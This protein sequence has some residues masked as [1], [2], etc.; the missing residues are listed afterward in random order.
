MAKPTPSKQKKNKADK[1]LTL[2]T[3]EK[4]EKVSEFAESKDRENDVTKTID[5]LAKNEKHCAKAVDKNNI[6]HYET[7]LFAVAGQRMLPFDIKEER[8]FLAL[9]VKIFNEGEM[10]KSVRCIEYM[11]QKRWGYWTYQVIRKP[12]DIPCCL[13]L[14]P[15]GKPSR[16]PNYYRHLILQSE[17]LLPG[18]CRFKTK[19]FLEIL[20]HGTTPDFSYIVVESANVSL[21]D[22]RAKVL[23]GADYSHTTAIQIGLQ[24]LQAINDSFCCSVL[25]RFIHPKNLFM[26][27]KEKINTIFIVD[28]SMGLLHCSSYRSISGKET[29]RAQ[30]RYP[31]LDYRY[32]PRAYH[33]YEDHLT[34][35]EV[36]SFIYV[37]LD[38]WTQ[39][40][41]LSLA[42]NE[43][44]SLVAKQSLLAG[45]VSSDYGPIVDA[46]SAMLRF[47]ESE[48]LAKRV[49]GQTCPEYTFY[50]N[51]LLQLAD[52]YNM[53]LAT[54]LDWMN[55]VVVAPYA[56]KKK[57]GI[58]D[59]VVEFSPKSEPERIRKLVADGILKV[60]KDEGPPKAQKPMAKKYTP[61]VDLNPPSPSD[62]AGNIA[63]KANESMP[64]ASTKELNTIGGGIAMSPSSPPSSP[65]PPPPPAS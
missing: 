40:N 35:E 51:T 3:I 31:F 53:D 37:F 14:E 28:F 55:P 27:R 52:E 12:D 21:W 22:F 54:P 42:T 41:P 11:V 1:E 59:I 46:V 36:E 7:S 13:R 24:V 62:A 32:M 43:R 58:P 44:E 56:R 2:V 15:I 57:A 45:Y 33:S 20:E 64:L 9:P 65:N 16:M 47:N 30:R 38:M 39:Y 23:G 10:F 19:H 26:G 29:P 34:F 50:A 48:K 25:S 63:S 6:F 17:M 49:K 18:R 60:P 4:P 5:N 61:F 8:E